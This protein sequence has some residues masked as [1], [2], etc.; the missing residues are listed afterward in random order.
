MGRIVRSGRVEQKRRHANGR[1]VVCVVQ[2]KFSSTD[3]GIIAAASS[4][5]KRIPTNSGIRGTSSKALKCLASFRC[6]EIGIASVRRWI[7]CW[8]FWRQRKA[9]I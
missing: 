2:V 8:S 1:I 3:S 7:D 5:K 6:R 9:E 4:A